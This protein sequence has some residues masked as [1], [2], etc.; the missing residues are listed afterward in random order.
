MWRHRLLN[1]F[2][3][4][5]ISTINISNSPISNLI[6]F[7]KIIFFDGEDESNKLTQGAG[8]NHFGIREKW[9]I[10][11]WNLA[12]NIGPREFRPSVTLLIASNIPMIEFWPKIRIGTLLNWNICKH[13]SVWH[14]RHFILQEMQKLQYK[15]FNRVA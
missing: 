1:T 13:F 2:N 5:N 14:R 3:N 7:V 4:F 15:I 8:R 12:I 9:G 10:Y 6:N 11:F